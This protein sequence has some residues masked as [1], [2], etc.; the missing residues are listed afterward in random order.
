MT[1]EKYEQLR[2]KIIEANPEIMELK[3]GCEFIAP[4]KER[5]RIIYYS[6]EFNDSA[7]VR[8]ISVK[9]PKF[10]SLLTK[11]YHSIP[12]IRYSPRHKFSD[13]NLQ[14]IGRPIR[15]ADVLLAI[16]QLPFFN[17]LVTKT[18]N[19]LTV[20]ERLLGGSIFNGYWNLRDD[21]LDNQSDECKEFLYKLLVE[22]NTN[23]THK[24]Q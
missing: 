15:L 13:L 4:D 24:K 7:M 10:P 6:G 1:T 20:V 5:G 23:A 14:I 2:Q 3:F 19:N 17:L 8:M 12:A 18:D 11:L 9:H 21:N 22:G 16:E